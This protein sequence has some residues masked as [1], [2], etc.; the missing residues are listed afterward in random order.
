MKVVISSVIMMVL[1][2]LYDRGHYRADLNKKAFVKL[3]Q[4][5]LLMTLGC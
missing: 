2:N 1:Q 4:S 3:N 5:I